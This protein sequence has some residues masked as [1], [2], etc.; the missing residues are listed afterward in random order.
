[1]AKKYPVFCQFSMITNLYLTSKKKSE[2]INTFFEQKYSVL[3]NGKR[4]PMQSPLR[5][6]KKNQMFTSL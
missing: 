6:S 5:T 3:D 4:L 1:M 2:V